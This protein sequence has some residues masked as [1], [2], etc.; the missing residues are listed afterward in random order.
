MGR[1][2]GPIVGDGFRFD[3]ARAIRTRRLAMGLTQKQAA[4]R[5]GLT[6]TAWQKIESG[7]GDMMLH[8]FCGVLRV[9]KLSDKP[10]SDLVAMVVRG[11]K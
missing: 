3:M 9:L 5:I 2:C 4:A 11:A 1:R 6:K 8:T 7:H 10:W